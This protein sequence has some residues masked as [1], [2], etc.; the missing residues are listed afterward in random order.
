[1]P[2]EVI[3]FDALHA[4]ASRADIVIT[5]T[6]SPQHLF[7]RQHGQQFIQRRRGRPMFFI[8]IAVPRDVD[9]RTNEVEGCFV[10]DIDDLQQVAQAHQADR[11]REAAAAERIITDEVARYQQRQQALDAV[12]AIRALQTQADELRR[13]ELAR[14]AKALADLSPEQAA[15][16]EALT[17][18]L[19]AKF[20]H[21]PLMAIRAAAEAGDTAELARLQ[22]LYGPR[23]QS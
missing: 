11:N 22:A 6:G 14:T 18:S 8:D 2:V 4:E 3:P 1:V 5:S 12:P 9:P 17:R 7:V 23:T 13:A 10:Y 15:A 16:V 20:L 19:T 21:A